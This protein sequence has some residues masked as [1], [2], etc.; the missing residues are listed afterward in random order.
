M[1]WPIVLLSLTK[2][3]A[4]ARPDQRKLPASSNVVVDRSTSSRKEILRHNLTN[5]S[6][7]LH[8]IRVVN[9]SLFSRRR[10]LRHDL[11]KRN[12]PASSNVSGRSL[13]SL[14]ERS[15]QH[16]LTNGSF[17][18]HRM[19]WPIVLLL[20]RK[21]IATAQP[22]QR[23]LPASSNKVA[24][25]STSCTKR[26][27][28]H[29]LTNGSFLLHRMWWPIVLL[30]SRKE[31]LR[32]NLTNG[33]S[34][35]HRMWWPIVLLLARK[36]IATAQPDQRKLPASS[37]MVAD[38][39]TSCTKGDSATRPDQRKLP[40]SSNVVADRST[41]LT[42]G[43]ATAQPDQRKLPASSNVVADRSTSLKE[44]LGTT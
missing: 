28:Q 14:H 41:S 6:I 20:S 23:K 25:R 2:G 39:S 9:R 29:D 27:L 1:W 26:Y 17:L 15:L 42:K 37:N 31:M 8:R 5:G 43:D 24:D 7:P 35:L 34:L 44:Y 13:L 11:T 16:D 4:A 19:W 32:H 30:L 33:S 40:A 12:L 10:S 3:D 18:L 21:E 36:E 38:R 22:D